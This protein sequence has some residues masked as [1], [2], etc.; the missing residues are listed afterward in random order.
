MENNGW[1]MEHNVSIANR[2]KSKALLSTIIA[3]WLASKLGNFK[4]IISTS[5]KYMHYCQP[6]VIDRSP[7]MYMCYAYKSIIVNMGV[8]I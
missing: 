3:I 8:K 5:L 1:F 6:C 4:S 2:Q 7:H